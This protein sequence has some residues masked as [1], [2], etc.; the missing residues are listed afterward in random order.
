MPS[1]C[2]VECLRTDRELLLGRQNVPHEWSNIDQSRHPKTTPPA[3]MPLPPTPLPCASIRRHHQQLRNAPL[4]SPA[5]PS[6]EL[7]SGPP[8]RARNR[9]A[10]ASP[11]PLPETGRRCLRRMP[12]ADAALLVEH[13]NLWNDETPYPRPRSI[14]YLGIPAFGRQLSIAASRTQRDANAVCQPLAEPHSGKARGIQTQIHGA[15]TVRHRQAGDRFR[16]TI[17]GPPRLRGSPVM[18]IGISLHG[19]ESHGYVGPCRV[20]AFRT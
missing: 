7:P 12:P 6:G 4:D 17:S 11:E 8:T 10:T 14:P 3:A 2:F 18:T 15:R 16:R 13:V 1:Q 9:E 20:K 5:T 19:V